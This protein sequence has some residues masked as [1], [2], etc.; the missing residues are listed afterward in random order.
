MRSLEPYLFEGIKECQ[1]SVPEGAAL[2]VL[3]FWMSRSSLQLFHSIHS[4]AVTRFRCQVEHFNGSIFVVS[5]GSNYQME[6]CLLCGKR[7]LV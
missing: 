3:A 6:T 4:S 5:L 7:K 1:E 2:H